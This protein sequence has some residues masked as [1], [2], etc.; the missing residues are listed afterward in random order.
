RQH[1]ND[2]LFIRVGNEMIP[3]E[4]AKQIFPL[5]SEVIDKVESINNFNVNFDPL[6]SDQLFTIAMTDV[7]HLVLLP[8]LT[9]YLK[10][11]A[12]LI[13]L[14]IR[15][16]T[17]ET[18]YQMANGEIDLAIGF[19]PQLE[20]GFYQQKFFRQHY[21]VISSK[22]HPRLDPNNFTL[23]DYMRESHID[24]DAGIGHYHIKNELQNKGL[25]RNILIRLP[26]YLGVGLVVQETDAIA[27]VPYYLSQVLLVRENLQILPAP[28]DFPTY[29]V[30]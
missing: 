22:S 23:E 6:T 8:Q 14:N 2:P 1:F 9:N 15:P 3:T 10:E 24:I 17:P 16:I 29:D 5:I 11:K 20:E 27:T 18:S 21:V 25:D 26:S 7:S 12:P 13:R 28:L 4:L 30:K 19:L